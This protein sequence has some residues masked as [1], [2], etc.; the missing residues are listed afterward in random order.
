[1]HHWVPRDMTTGTLW[2]V[3]SPI[4]RSSYIINHIIFVTS[5]SVRRSPVTYIRTQDFTMDVHASS[6]LIIPF[7]SPPPLCPLPIIQVRGSRECTVSFLVAPHPTRP[8]NLFYGNKMKTAPKD[9]CLGPPGS[10]VTEWPD[11]DS[12]VSVTPASM[13]RTIKL[14]CSSHTLLLKF[15]A[16]PLEASQAI[17]Q[18]TARSDRF[19]Q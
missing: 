19:L 8:P 14:L 16:Q 9:L 10:R 1:M 2:T 18:Q 17:S 12:H 13:V 3:A 11:V 6:F 15:N 7:L 5:H 4:I